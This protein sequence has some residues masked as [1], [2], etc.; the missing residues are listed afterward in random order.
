MLQN[1]VLIISEERRR[2]LQTIFVAITMP[3]RQTILK[4]KLD[5]RIIG[6]V[7]IVVARAFNQSTYKVCTPSQPF[8]INLDIIIM[9]IELK[10]PMCYLKNV[11]QETLTIYPQEPSKFRL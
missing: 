7:T 2:R 6:H 4:A 3:I 11:L 1:F 8:H 9:G 5:E 10:S